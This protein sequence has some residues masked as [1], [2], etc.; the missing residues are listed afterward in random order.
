MGFA[1]GAILVTR[2]LM[3]PN[4]SWSGNRFNRITKEIQC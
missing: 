3:I 2:F 1:S 4:S